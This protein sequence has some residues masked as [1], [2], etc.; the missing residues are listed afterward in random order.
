MVFAL[1]PPPSQCTFFYMRNRMT[2]RARML[3]PLSVALVLSGCAAAT[4]GYVPPSGEANKLALPAFQSGT[5]ANGQYEPSADEKKLDCRKLTGS[6]QVMVSRIK[7]APNRARPTGAAAAIQG[8]AA[9][10]LGGSTVGSNFEGEL[11][12]E[13]ARLD[14][15]NR[16]LAEK[17]CKTMDIAA[18]LAKPR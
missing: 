3:S 1:L 14:A 9:P 17:K 11:A 7:D 13:R 4:P 12:R 5:V 2:E 18:E 8:V 10:V 16:L 15:Y 6:M